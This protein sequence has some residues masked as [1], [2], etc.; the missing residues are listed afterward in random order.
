MLKRNQI[1]EENLPDS[2]INQISPDADIVTDE[3]TELYYDSQY[4]YLF[5]HR[6]NLE[7][8]DNN[9]K[10][11]LSH[12]IKYSDITTVLGQR[13]TLV[14]MADDDEFGRGFHVFM[15]IY[16]FPKIINNLSYDNFS[17]ILEMV[18]ETAM[19]TIYEQKPNYQMN[20]I[21]PIEGNVVNEQN[22]FCSI[23]QDAK[24]LA[25]EEILKCP[26][27]DGEYC[28]DLYRIWPDKSLHVVSGIPQI[29]IYVT[30]GKVE[31]ITANPFKS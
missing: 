30:K 14:F 25:Y 15:G 1:M 19:V 27:D 11:R 29:G 13:Q 9:M 12:P 8:D 21:D 4:N 23:E 22:Y 6:D 16:S 26:L 5:V 10:V 20:V 24:R 31:I 3:S 2:I 28:A 18:S 7:C 17:F